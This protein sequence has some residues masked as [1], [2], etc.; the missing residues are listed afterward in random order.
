MTGRRKKDPEI[1]CKVVGGPAGRP[2]RFP[3][4]DVKRGWSQTA[5]VWVL[6]EPLPDRVRVGQDWYRLVH[7]NGKPFYVHVEA[8]NLDEMVRRLVLG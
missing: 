6:T 5:P 4:P 1:R 7:E 3:N 2:I 8:V